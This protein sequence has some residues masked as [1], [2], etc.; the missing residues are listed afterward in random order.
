VPFGVF[1]VQTHSPPEHAML[2]AEQLTPHEPQLLASDWTFAHAPLQEVSPVLQVHVPAP[3][4]LEPLAHAL[5]HAPQLLLSLSRLTQA[6]PQF[7]RPALQVTTHVEP[8]H[9]AVPSVAPLLGPGHALVHEVPQWFAVE[10]GSHVPLQLSV[11]AEHP[12]LPPEQDDPPVHALPHAP[13]LSLSVPRLTQAPAQFVRPALQ[14]KAHVEPLQDAVPSVAPLLGPGHA[15]MHEVP[16]WLAVEGASHVPSQLIVP[17]EHPQL[18]PE[19]DDPPVQALAHAPQLLLSLLRL[20]Q[21]PPQFV[22]PVLHV[23]A[24]VE[25]LQDVVPSVA[26]LLGPGHALVH[27]VPQSLAVEGAS[28]VP[29]QLSVPE[30]QP[31]VLLLATQT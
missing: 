13:Q 19:Q 2:R 22:R 15:L 27:E 16:Q 18:P 26:P 25:P 1:A 9:D 30:G 24:H 3:E 4:Q 11:P 31:Q 20:T 7:V 29:L 14:V 23:K 6:P 21:A 12:Q 28:H 8:L 10:G 17:A 5:P